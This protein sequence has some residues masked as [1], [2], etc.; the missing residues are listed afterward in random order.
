MLLFLFSI[1]YSY[2]IYDIASVLFTLKACEFHIWLH[3]TET[4]L[5]SSKKMWN[6][7]AQGI[8]NTTEEAI[9]ATLVFNALCTQPLFKQEPRRT[10]CSPEKQFHSVWLKLVQWIWRRCFK[11]SM[12]FNYFIIIFLDRR[13]TLYLNKLESSS[14]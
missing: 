5:I 2:N 13:V 3:C 6:N 4:K 9:H 8:I 12:Y 1:R 11:L 14:S 7:N 10:H